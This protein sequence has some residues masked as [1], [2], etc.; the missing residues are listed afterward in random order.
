[1]KN[2]L[3]V[4]QDGPAADS[5]VSELRRQ[6][7]AARSVHAGRQVL[8]ACRDADLVLLSLDLTDVDGL[9]VCRSLRAV[10]NVPLI[11]R[12]HRDDELERVLALREG[13]DDCVAKTWGMRELRARIEAVLRRSRCGKA[14]PETISIEPL[15]IDQRTRE[16]RLHDQRVDVTS[17]EFELLYALAANPETVVSRKQL[18]ASVWGTNWASSSRTIDTH[19]SS[20]RAKLGSNRWIIT[21]RGVG[22]RLGHARTVAAG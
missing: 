22:Y 3:V 11:A 9:E 18:M 21:V 20:L 19:V 15:R 5:V 13:A 6:G 12:T 7:Y 1:M 10:S 2:I 16:V 8:E 4:E 14:E 17:K